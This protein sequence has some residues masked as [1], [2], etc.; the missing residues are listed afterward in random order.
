MKSA[1]KLAQLADEYKAAKQ[2]RL[3][4][5]KGAKPLKER[6]TELYN[7]LYAALTE[8]EELN[9]VVGKTCVAKIVYKRVSQVNDWESVYD[10]IK[11]NSAF[12]LLPKRLSE[13]AVREHW[14]AGEAIPGVEPYEVA[15]LSITKV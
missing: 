13:P 6:E 7:E 3:D 5:E 8:N 9:G 12:E 2:A 14:E 10:F 11:K 15:T 1:T 4:Y